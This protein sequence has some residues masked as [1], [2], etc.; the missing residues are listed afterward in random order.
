MSNFDALHPTGAGHRFITKSGAPCR[1]SAGMPPPPVPYA[2]PYDP[3]TPAPLRSTPV[4]V[5]DEE[6]GGFLP[7]EVFEGIHADE[8]VLPSG[9]EQSSDGVYNNSGGVASTVV[10]GLKT[11]VE[12]FDDNDPRHNPNI[13][14]GDL[15]YFYVPDGYVMSPSERQAA[16]DV[17]TPDQTVWQCTT[18]CEQHPL[19][20]FRAVVRP[21]GCVSCEDEHVE[22]RRLAKLGINLRLV[23]KTRAFAFRV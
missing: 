16:V 20:E 4:G 5:W 2:Q 14:I 1:A 23:D 18:C 22:M 10:A 17:N 15:D 21:G 13:R 8:M 3:Y 6:Y 11:I 19:A 9:G 12:P 7:A